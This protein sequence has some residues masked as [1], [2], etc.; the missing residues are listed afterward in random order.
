[1]PLLGL[2]TTLFPDALL[3]DDSE[4]G[5]ARRWMVVYT[6]PRQEKALSRE[7]LRQQIPFYLPLVKKT[8]YHQRRKRSSYTPLFPG[9]VFLYASEA[10]RIRTLATNRVLRVLWVDDAERLVSDLRQLR[11]LI[12][13]NAPLTVESRLLPGDRVRVRKGPFAG[14][15]GTVLHRRGQARLLVSINFLQRG[16]SVEIEDFLLEPLT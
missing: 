7:I 9:Y 8:L 13:S 2:E 11:R 1:M 5:D 6:K 12:S 4:P 14:I 10:E 15:E 3:D 16:A